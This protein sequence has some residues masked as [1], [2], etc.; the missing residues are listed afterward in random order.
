MLSLAKVVFDVYAS[1]LVGALVANSSLDDTQLFPK[2]ASLPLV[3]GRSFVAD[4]FCKA[5]QD[6][7]KERPSTFWSEVDW[8][9]MLVCHESVE[10]VLVLSHILWC[11]HF[12]KSFIHAVECVYDKAVLN[13]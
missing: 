9:S 1:L 13:N 3:E 5:I 11:A 4:E 7:V 10:D 8:P 6:K 2:L 12:Q